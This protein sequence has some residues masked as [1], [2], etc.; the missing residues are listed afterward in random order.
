MRFSLLSTLVV[1]LAAESAVASTGWF[2]KAAY[3]KWHETE[4]ERWLSDHNI[5]YP[6]PADRKDLEDLVK[7]NWNS[8]VVQPYN[9]WDTARLQSYL[10]EK[11][12]DLQKGA[13]DSRDTLLET[14]KS[15]WGETEDQTTDAYS[16]VRDWIFDSWTDSQLKAFLDRNGIPAPQP[17]T[18]DTLLKTARENYETV[19]KKIGETASYPGN[20]LY[21]SW[22]DSDLKAWLDE[23]GYPAPQP[24]SRDKLIAA[25]RR[26][27]RLATESIKSAQASAA[28]S[29]SAA[30][31]SLTD[32]LLDAWSDSQIKEWLDKNGVKV[33][34]GS[35][36]NELTALA[37]KH[38]A[39]LTGDNLSYSAS[40]AYGAAT[41]RAGNEYAKATDDA[42]LK[43]EHL[44]GSAGYYV[45][46]IKEKLG[47][48]GSNIA[49]A[50]DAAQS[51]ATSAYSAAAKD[52]TKAGY[53]ANEK[54][55]SIKH[56]GEEAAQTATDYVK[57][58]L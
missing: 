2:G 51:S 12:H 24:S 39:K 45:E 3:N 31:H 55:S 35:K 53:A 28:A 11:G 29:A 27:S 36:R 23:R 18:R 4:L 34:Q 20:W 19:A 8:K 15:Y 26:N 9:E 41:S 54:A 52:A 6:T 32:A 38:R 1:A 30:Q 14:V 17:R 5:P 40:S 58:E 57:E 10:G 25:V 47:L 48:A 46:W 56:R 33:P 43:K 22:S 44:A 50:T 7:D 42:A 49:S 16:K 13:A 21:D 37:R